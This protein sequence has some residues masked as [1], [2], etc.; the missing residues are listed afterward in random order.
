MH[1][2]P[3]AVLKRGVRCHQVP[4]GGQFSTTAYFDRGLELVSQS[5]DHVP[6]RVIPA[7]PQRASDVLAV[8]ENLDKPGG[9]WCR[10]SGRTLKHRLEFRQGSERLCTFLAGHS[11]RIVT[12]EVQT[13]YNHAPDEGPAG[14]FSTVNEMSHNVMDIPPSR[15][16]SRAPLGRLKWLE[17]TYQ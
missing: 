8:N 6:W 1:F 3:I 4:P 17:V 15:E 13:G 14:C 7:D 9:R 16:G 11:C 12:I 2:G 5:G 10:R